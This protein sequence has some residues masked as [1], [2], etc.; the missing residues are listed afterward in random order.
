MNE[1]FVTPEKLPKISPLDLTIIEIFNSYK[2]MRISTRKNKLTFAYKKRLAKK[3][4]F[5]I[6][7]SIGE[8]LVRTKEKKI[9][10]VLNNEPIQESEID[11][12]KEGNMEV[13]RNDKCTDC[14]I[15]DEKT[16]SDFLEKE[17]ILKKINEI[18]NMNTWFL[19]Q[20]NNNWDFNFEKSFLLAHYHLAKYYEIVNK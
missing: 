13:D 20:M 16:N 4:F 2:R 11:S 19:E 17:N 3:K 7:K 6:K 14:S 1:I 5:K 10:K 18:K 8:R 15:P 9:E 12:K